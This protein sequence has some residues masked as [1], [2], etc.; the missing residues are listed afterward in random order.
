MKS[1]F[2]NSRRPRVL[3]T[4]FLAAFSFPTLPSVMASSHLIY[5]GTYTRDGSKGIYSAR[6]DDTTGALSAPQIAAETADPAWITLSPNKK[7]LYAIHA[8]PA[9]AVGF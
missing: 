7:F 3:L 9:Q 4:L 1:S 6:L 2:Q 5:F 8:S